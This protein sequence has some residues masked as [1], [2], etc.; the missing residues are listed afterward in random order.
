MENRFNKKLNE[1]YISLSHDNNEI[2]INVYSFNLLDNIKYEMN[3]SFDE[4]KALSAFFTNYNNINEIYNILVKIINQNKIKFI[5]KNKDILF[6]FKFYDI[7]ENALDKNIEFILYPQRERDENNYL[8]ALVNEIK[9]LRSNNE[10]LILENQKLKNELND[11]MNQNLN[12]NT[13]RNVD[14]YI[15]QNNNMNQNLNIS[16]NNMNMNQN[17]N[18]NQ[19][20][21]ISQNNMNMSQNNNMN[22]N[23]N[24]SQK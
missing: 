4:L 5:Q 19:N 17:N 23:V 12:S 21:N 7:D 10:K 9:L 14:Q 2:T 11:N 6:C 22:Q 16:Q 1:Y 24:I 13:N 18:M 8:E 3:F 15:N 20:V